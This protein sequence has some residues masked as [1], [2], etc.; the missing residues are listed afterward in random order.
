M[1]I[2]LEKCEPNNT[3]ESVFCVVGGGIAGIIIANQLSQFVP[4]S[5]IL[6]VDAGDHRNKKIYFDLLEGCAENSQIRKDSLHYGIGGASN[7]W[8]G[9]CSRFAENELDRSIFDAG[10]SWPIS[11]QEIEKYY[12][13]SEEILGLTG[14]LVCADSA[15]EGG[16]KWRRLAAKIPAKN[17]KWDL[18]PKNYK[19]LKNCHVTKISTKNSRVSSVSG[20]SSVSGN[21]AEIYCKYV[22]LLQPR[23]L[24]TNRI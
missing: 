15:D 23:I 1:I 18:Y 9:L 11:Y 3:V 21:N 4:Q 7:V 5:D 17:F 2:D 16:G 10:A 12:E 8:G 19:V 22:I 13:K 6:L 20:R 14:H 24:C